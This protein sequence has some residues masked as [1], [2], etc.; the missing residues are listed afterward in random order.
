MEANYHAA[1]QLPQPDGAINRQ[2]LAA[3]PVTWA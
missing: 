2:E 1:S 3:L